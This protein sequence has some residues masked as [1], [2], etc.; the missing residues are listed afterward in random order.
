MLWRTLIR[1]L[2]GMRAAKKVQD[3][4]CFVSKMDISTVVEVGDLTLIHADS[5]TTTAERKMMVS[6]T[7]DPC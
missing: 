3:T 6:L 7:V 5:T 1:A 4:T 2:L